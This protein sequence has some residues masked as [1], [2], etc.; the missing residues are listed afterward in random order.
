MPQSQI[1]PGL[2]V[3]QVEDMGL[4]PVNDSTLRC[5]LWRSRGGGEVRGEFGSSGSSVQDFRPNKIAELRHHWHPGSPEI[6]KE[7]EKNG[8]LDAD[9]ESRY[10]RP[11]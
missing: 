10:M 6:L 8:H 5:S 2:V 11:I 4:A 7:C 1:R 3:D 9:L